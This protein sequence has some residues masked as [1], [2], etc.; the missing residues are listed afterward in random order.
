M[1]IDDEEIIQTVLSG[2]LNQL[3]YR[4][5]QARSGKEGIELLTA[6]NEADA[7]LLD[8]V[9]PGLS[10]WETYRYLR[11][12]WPRI[13]VIVITGYANQEQIR[14]MLEDGLAGI[15]EKPFRAAQI[16]EKLKQVLEN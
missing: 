7:V 10:G 5:F 12:Y 1:V 3:G 16:A 11:T 2:I 9:M 15:V 8:M 13:P 14:A 4:T 6:G